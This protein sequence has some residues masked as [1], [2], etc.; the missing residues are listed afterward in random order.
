MS[1]TPRQRVAVL[2]S[3]RGSNMGALI[4]A[5]MDPG[6]PGEIALVLSNRPDAAGLDTA[7]RYHV[8]AEAIDHKLYPSR[9]AHEAAMTALLDEVRPDVICLAGY[10]RI[11][12]PGFV[13]RHL[14]RMINI[15]PSLLP[16]FPGLHTH[17]RALAAG[18]RIH[19]CTSHFVTEVMD[20]G[21][22][23]AQAAVPIEAGDTPDS[24]ADRLLRA[25]HR[26]Y[27]HAL[28]LVLTGAVRMENGRA[29]FARGEAADLRLSRGD[30]TPILLSPEARLA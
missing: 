28:R 20:E 7:R 19:G 24:L 12:T 9:E 29:V 25:E 15:H 16:L 21:P 10:M 4:A 8:R 17:E 27:P 23:I 5:A 14:G 22:I 26:L 2:I 1:A 11:L 30:G 3:G 18:M 6:F 13:Q